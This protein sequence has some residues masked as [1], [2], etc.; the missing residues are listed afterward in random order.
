MGTRGLAKTLKSSHVA[1]M[2]AVGGQPLPT[3]W[4]LGH[5]VA[6]TRTGYP[7][8]ICKIHRRQLRQGDHRL[9]SLYLSLCSIYRVLDYRG[10]LDLATITSPGK[11]FNTLPYI[12]FTPIFGKLLSG[13]TQTDNKITDY[14]VEAKLF[15]KSGPGTVSKPIIAR[16]GQPSIAEIPNTTAALWPQAVSWCLPQHSDLKSILTTF[17]ANLNSKSAT[18]VLFTLDQIG[19]VGLLVKR[20]V[21]FAPT[22][23]GKLGV[24][25]EPGKVRVFA[26]VDWWTQIFLRPL[27]LH[28]FG[29]LKRIPQDG[30]YDQDKAF[31]K[32]IRLIRMTHYAASYDL[33][34][35]T[36]R[37]PVLLQAFLINLL[38]PNTGQL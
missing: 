3:S 5:P 13:I 21:R 23:L 12:D 25:F 8:W 15:Q 19:G 29:I 31:Q 36:D 35:A 38:I 24:K 27:H 10:K 14:V 26:M 34:A 32:G 11:D 4:L 30:T 18:N 16:K 17:V 7:R 9:I 6:L 22:F 20:L 2:R 37:L 1:L 28:I 33:S